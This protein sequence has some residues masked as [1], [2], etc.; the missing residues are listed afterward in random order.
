MII[1][2][3]Q[4]AANGVGLTCGNIREFSREIEENC[5]NLQVAE[6]LAE[7]LAGN[8]SEAQGGTRPLKFGKD[9]WSK[10][11]GSSNTYQRER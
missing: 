9:P 11:I 7:I 10:G 5:G 6:I 8:A 1:G 2:C 4:S 3:E